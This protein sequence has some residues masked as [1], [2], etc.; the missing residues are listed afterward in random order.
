MIVLCAANVILHHGEVDRPEFIPYEHLRI[1]TK[2]FPWG[3]GNHTLFH[4]RHMNALPTG[5]EENPGED[6]PEDGEGN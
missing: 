1:R 2:K 3:D 4:N 5:Y 6:L